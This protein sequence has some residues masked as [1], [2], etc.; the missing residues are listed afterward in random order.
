[1]MFIIIKSWGFPC[2]S[3]GYNAYNTGDKK[4]AQT[5]NAK[6]EPLVKAMFIETNP[7]PVKAAMGLLD[8]CAPDVRLPLC[9]MEADN[10]EK[11]KTALQKYGLLKG[12]PA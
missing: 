7:I 4:E 10:N 5:I 3:A 6:L 12:Q 9:E 1:M 2:C 11:L 8:L